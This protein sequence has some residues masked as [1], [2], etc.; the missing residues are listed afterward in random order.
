MSLNPFQL[1][2][3]NK[4]PSHCQPYNYSSV[5]PER[6][7]LIRER[8]TEI[9]RMVGEASAKI[10]EI[11]RALKAV[12]KDLPHGE[13]GRWLSAE[14]G[15]TER[16]AQRM[17]QVYEVFGKKADTVSVLEPTS[18]YILAAP[19]T[20]EDVRKEAVRRLQNG[21]VLSTPVVKAMVDKDR[22][23]QKERRAEAN[24][25]V[26]P[27]KVSRIEKAELAAKLIIDNLGDEGGRLGMLLIGV[28]A[29]EL[30]R[31]LRDAIASM[32]DGRL[33]ELRL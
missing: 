30:V 11:G 19:S 8:A 33:G 1:T 22:E 14:F 29:G 25:Q 31:C 10:F 28:N 15:W 20:S 17:L 21:D 23:A 16:T 2:A 7:T 9:K 24:G 32:N 4:S 27:P 12:K 13:F 18:L 26:H 3:M 6:A 5:T